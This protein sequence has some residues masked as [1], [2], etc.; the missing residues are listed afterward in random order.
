MLT[1]TPRA[2]I[3]GTALI[4][5]PNIKDPDGFYEELIESQRDLTDEEAQNMNCRLILLLANHIG[6]RGVLREAL[7]AAGPARKA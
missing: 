1:E 6:H 2:L 4:R 5:T 7:Q 3:D